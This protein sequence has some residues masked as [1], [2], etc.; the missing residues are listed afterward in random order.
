MRQIY[1]FSR[2][3]LDSLKVFAYL[4]AKEHFKKG[5]YLFKQDDDDGQAFY[6]FSGSARLIRETPDAEM[7]IRDYPEE[8]FIG[9]MMLLSRIR[10]LYS[11]KATEDLSCLVLS[12]EKFQKAMEQF[13][14]LMPKVTRAL[15]EQVFAWEEHFLVHRADTYE[16][17]IQKGGLSLI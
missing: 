14:D 15:I 4:C 5:E 10:R 12:R 8:T 16:E 13:P 17:C 6:L 1:L 2:F 3:P 9:G 11:L 7:V